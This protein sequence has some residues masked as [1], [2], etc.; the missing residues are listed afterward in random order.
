M[1]ELLEAVHQFHHE[2]DQ[3]RQAV[4]RLLKKWANVI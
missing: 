3:D 4:L 1:P 2:L